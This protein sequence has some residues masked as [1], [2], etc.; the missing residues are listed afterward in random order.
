MKV[1]DRETPPKSVRRQV[2]EAAALIAVV[3]TVACCVMTVL[4]LGSSPGAAATPARDGAFGYSA[5]E[6]SAAFAQAWPR[7]G[8]L[9]LAMIAAC[10]L[11]AVLGRMKRRLR[12]KLDA[13]RSA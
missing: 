7:A 13:G 3:F 1:A 11:G 5:A 6:W 9:V 2:A 8:G 12:E 4:R 10:A